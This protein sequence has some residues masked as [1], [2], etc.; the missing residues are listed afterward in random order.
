MF[1]DTESKVSGFREV[2]LSKFVL[3]DLEATL[4]DL[5]SLRATDG[6]VD[7][8]FFV[9]TDTERS[10]GVSGFRRDGCLTGELF[11]HLGSPGQSVSRFTDGDV[12]VNTKLHQSPEHK[13]V[14][15]LIT[16]FSIRSSFIEFVGA[17]IC[18]AC[19]FGEWKGDGGMVRWVSLWLNLWLIPNLSTAHLTGDC[20]TKGRLIR[21]CSQSRVQREALFF[22]RP[23]I[24]SRA[25]IALNVLDLV[26]HSY[27]Y[28]VDYKEKRMMQART[29]R[30]GST[31]SMGLQ[32]V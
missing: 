7:G 11:K 16:S 21:L 31:V 4:E 15:A 19:I 25:W 23:E 6:N 32:H 24:V 29:D 2:P 9:T 27:V 14:D 13:V 10:D 1:L 18:S 8:D 5:L 30:N 3:L 20:R 28:T 17:V 22:A 26:L 12:C